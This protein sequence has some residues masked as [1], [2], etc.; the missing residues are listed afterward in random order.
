MCSIRLKGSRSLW[1]THLPS[2]FMPICKHFLRRQAWH[3]FRCC[4]SIVQF[5]VPAW[6]L[7]V[8]QKGKETTAKGKKKK[9]GH[10][11]EKH[12]LRNGIE[13]S[14]SSLY[15]LCD[16]RFQ[17]R[18]SRLVLYPITSCSSSPT[19]IA[20]WFLTLLVSVSPLIQHK[21]DVEE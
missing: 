10:E 1:V 3:W 2:L 6:H 17:K 21:T 14:L 9:K 19:A 20:A 8:V 16:I 18:C 12:R 13:C 4:L 11:I 5:P 7:H 15:F